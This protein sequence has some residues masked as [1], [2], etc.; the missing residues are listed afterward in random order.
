MQFLQQVSDN[1]TSMAYSY[2]MGGQ[3]PPGGQQ[4]MQQGQWGQQ[5]QQH[6]GYMQ[7]GQP[8]PPQ[9]QHYGSYG[10]QFQQNVFSVNAW[11]VQYRL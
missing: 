8:P 9:S 6:G 1:V 11:Q 2:P 4:M 7:A 10:Q 5:Q 3:P